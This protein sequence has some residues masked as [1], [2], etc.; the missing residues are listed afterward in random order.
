MG[1]NKITQLLASVD[2]DKRDD[3]LEKLKNLF[4]EKKT[5]TKIDFQKLWKGIYFCF[6]YYFFF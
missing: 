2:Q 4:I 1:V 6:D 3:A 5:L